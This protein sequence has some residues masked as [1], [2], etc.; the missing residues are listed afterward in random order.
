MVVEILIKTTQYLLLKKI[1]LISTYDIL[2]LCEKNCNL[3]A[4]PIISSGG[5]KIPVMK[6]YKMAS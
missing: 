2:R 5:E 6:E 3:H 4:Y 1:N